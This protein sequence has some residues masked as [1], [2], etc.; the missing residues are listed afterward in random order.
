MVAPTSIQ[1][2]ERK[3]PKLNSYVPPSTSQSR[4]AVHTSARFAGLRDGNMWV[5]TRHLITHSSPPSTSQ[6]S[7]PEEGTKFDFTAFDGPSMSMEDETLPPKRKHTAGDNPLLIWIGECHTYLSEIIRLDGRRENVENTC[8]GSCC[9]DPG[10]FR[11]R[12]CDDMQLYC[13]TCTLANHVWSPTHCIQ[14]W[15]GMFFKVTS[16]KTLG[17]CIQLG[18]PIGQRCILP[19]Q[20]FNDN[21]VLIDT[22]RIHEIGLDFCGCETSQTCVKQL[23]RHG[24]FPATSTDLRT[25]ATF[26]LLH[27][28]QILSFKSKASAYE[29]YHSLVHLTDNTG[30]M[31]RKDCYDAFMRMVHK[32]WHLTMLKCSGHGHDPNGIDGTSQGECMVLCLACPQ[33]GKNLPDGW[34]TVTKAKQWLYAVFLAINA[35]F[36]LKRC[37]VSSDQTDPS[38]LKGWAYFVEENDYKAFLAEHLA[39]AQEKSTCSSHNTVNMVD[40]KQ[41]QGLAATGVGTVDCAHHNFKRPNGV[42]DLQKG[43]KYINMDYLFFSTLHGMQLE[44]PNV[45]YDTVCQWHKN[46]WACMKCFPQSHGLDNLTKI[47]CFFVPKFHLPVHIAKCQTI[48][49]FNFTRFVGRTDGEAPERGWSN[50]N[51]MASSTK[52]MGPGC[53]HDTLNDHFG[54]W[55]WKKT[56]G[57]GASLLHKMKD[58]LVENAAHKLAFEE[59]NA[60]ITP[61]HCSAR[62][63]E[64]EA[65]EEN[66]ND[67]PKLWVTITQAGAWLKLMELEAEELQQG[68]DTSLHPDISPSVLIASG[69]DL[70]EEQ[71]HLGNIAELMGLHATDTQKGNLMRMRNSLHCRIDLWRRAQVLYLP[72]V[73]S[74]IDQAACEGY[75]NAKCIKLWLPSQLKTRPC[76]RRLQDDEWELRY[77]HAHDALEELQQ[78]LR[79]H[80]SLLTFKREWIRGQGANTQAQ[81]ALARVHQRMALRAL[82][83]IM[84]KKDW[85]GR[86]QELADDHVK[87]LVDPFATGEGRCQVLWIWMMDGVNCGDE[88]DNDSVRIEWCKSRVRASRWSEEVELLREEMRR[89]LQFFAWQRARWE[90]WGKDCIGEC[91]ADIEGL[92]VYAARQANIRQRLADHF[93]ILW[94]PFL[95]PEGPGGFVINDSPPE[96][97][98]PDLMIPDILVPDHCS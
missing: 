30:L 3:R 19:Q 2:I 13:A 93:H 50:I 77:A 20:A 31:K 29:F 70:E 92:Q 69:I 67:M 86:L 12:D 83:T 26:R 11:C 61:K 35:N 43:E 42:G 73:H 64:M 9:T 85:Q 62:L 32:W 97:S 80:C 51:P 39:D 17:L 36:R 4:D 60:A 53:R 28:Y 94:A 1:T 7:L 57:L 22:N 15:N 98:L 16:L 68:I 47:I 88:G 8:P 90:E 52:A 75:E 33:P 76:D 46:L 78:C 5:S 79:I 65:W 72:A 59:F 56:V 91:A 55:N 81:N 21:F 58:A 54:D 84:K 63:A 41:L 10:Q 96:D 23:L 49:S 71:R 18:H 25:A 38:L 74:L 40:M 45:S 44:M 6:S 34:Q 89:V 14:E 95:L 82:A 37:N 27:H 48:F 87:P 66:P 24:W